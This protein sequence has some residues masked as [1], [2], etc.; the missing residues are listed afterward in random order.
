MKSKLLPFS[1]LVFILGF[2]G[3]ILASGWADNGK[4]V[5]E[6]QDPTDTKSA[7]AYLNKI[8]SNQQTG[9]IDPN[10]V[11]QA[12]EQALQKQYKSGN[13]LGLNWVEMGPDNAP[14]RTRAVIFDNRDAS[15]LTL[16][17]AGVTGGLWKTTNQGLTWNKINIDN[18]NLY[19]TCLEQATDGTIYAGTGEGFCTEE[20]TYFGG[21]V[22]QGLYKSTDGNVFTRLS[23]TVPQITAAP[24]TV[25]WAYINEVKIDNNSG[26]VYAATNTGL[27][28]SDNGETNWTK[29]SQYYYD[30]VIYNVSLSIDSVVPCNSFEWVGDNLVLNGASYNS[31]VLDTTNYVKNVASSQTYIGEFNKPNCSDVDI[32]SD[33][34]VVATFNDLVFMAPG[35]SDMI[36]TNYSGSPTNPYVI[37]MQQRSYTTT[38]TAVDTADNTASRTVNFNT[39]T[40]WGPD[41]AD[42]TSPLSENTG[43]TNVAFAPADANVV[44]AVCTQHQGYLKNIYLSED[45]GQTWQVIFP[46]GAGI[47]EIFGGSGCFNNTLTVFPNDPYKILV[48]GY[49]MWMGSRAAGETGY[50]NWG[51]GPISQGGT[52]FLDAYLP[53]SHHDYVFQPGSNNKL[54]IATNNGIYYGVFKSTG[55]EFSG[56]NRKLSIT[57]SYT[58]GTSGSRHYVITGTQGNGVVYI[59]GEGN[60]PETGNQITGLS[61]GAS[62][63]SKIRPNAFIYGTSDGSLYRS[64]DRGMNSSFNFNPP[65][66][67]LFITPMALWENFNSQNSRD[68]VTFFATKTYYQGETLIARSANQGTDLGA[69]YPFTYVLQQDSLVEGDSIRIKDIIQS[70][71]FVATDGAVYMTK[72]AVKFSKEPAWWQIAEISGTPSCMAYSKDANYLFVGTED[73]LLY[74]ISNIAMAYDE[75]RADIGSETCIIAT[76]EIAFSGFESRFI[77]SVAVDQQN[78]EH[79]V[80][81]LGNYGNDAYVYNTY[82]AQDTATAINFVD[83]TGNLPHMPVYSSVI[84]ME[85][86]DYLIIG[87]EYGVYT[88]ESLEGDVMWTAENTGV[89]MIPVFQIKQQTIYKD[90]FILQPSDPNT[91]PVVYPKVTNYRDIYMATYGRGVWRD[92]TFRQEIGI[93]ETPHQQPTAN[94]VTVYPNPVRGNATLAFD[95]IADATVAVNIY[96]INGTLVKTLNQQPMHRGAQQVSVNCTDLP[97]GAYIVRVVAGNQVFNSKFIVK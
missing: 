7:E 17:S 92:E 26:R 86:S 67:T 35:G 50:Y 41:E 33:G 59:D 73:G 52:P 36:F 4:T 30:S 65:T 23:E 70:K 93:E 42:A 2:T 28:Y 49:N 88:T 61:G 48:G 72:D 6:N 90:G 55:V 77:T 53:F 18:Q 44:Y 5:G 47:L 38:L 71:L 14:G 40:A 83:I 54:A 24:D 97:A 60:T 32:A 85:N 29:V 34:T 25:D 9:Q 58:V 8:R 95:L 80:V 66:N 43:R 51:S 96:N 76:D 27:W 46:G 94:V 22:G 57:Q 56:I 45:K 81:T 11:L 68:S 82:N 21:L 13:A 63:I 91:E 1:L 87:T 62:L 31:A 15:G 19:I 79:I 10:D 37:S 69:G 3:M 89:G 75:A 78:A 20:E 64:E 12:R 84:E 16:I 39:E 74:R